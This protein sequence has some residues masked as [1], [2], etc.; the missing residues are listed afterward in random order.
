MSPS[1]SEYGTLLLEITPKVNRVESEDR[2]LRKK[3]AGMSGDAKSPQGRKMQSTSWIFVCLLVSL[4]RCKRFVPV[5]S[6]AKVRI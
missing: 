6:A 4:Q 5:K 1:H 2:A 3:P